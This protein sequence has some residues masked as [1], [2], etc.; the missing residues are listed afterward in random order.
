MPLVSV[1]VVT[2]NSSLFVSETLYSITEQTFKEIELIITDDCSTDDTVE[3]CRNWL[4]NNSQRFVRSRIITSDINTG[5]SGN[6]N[7]GLKAAG[8][9][10]IKT[11]GGDDTCKPGC[12]ED[13]VAWVASQPEIKVLFSFIE[14]YRLSFQPGNLIGITPR[15][16]NDPRSILASERSAESQYKMLLLSDRIHFTPSAFIHRE[17]LLSLGG[18]DERFK[19][20]EDYPLWLNL[21]RNGHKLYFMGKVTINYRQHPKAINN[22]GLNFL[23]NPNYFKNEE[24]RKCYIYPYLPTE[25]RLSQRFEYYISQVFHFNWLNKNNKISRFLLSL[26]LFL[27][28]FRYYIYIKKQLY[29]GLKTNEL[30]NS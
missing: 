26:L 4:N 22:T 20:L 18:F 29:P 19:L 8:G 16:T 13:N 11:I 24:F 2:Y 30:Y 3:V 21:T 6:A 17:T 9:E 5:V 10:W 1:I 15:F 27:N 28:P 12:I 25:I 7:R 23:I 14:N